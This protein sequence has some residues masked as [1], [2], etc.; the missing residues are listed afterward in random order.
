MPARIKPG[1]HPN[2]FGQIAMPKRYPA[3]RGSKRSNP[4]RLT[5]N[6]LS[7]NQTTDL[8]IAGSPYRRPKTAPDPA[9]FPGRDC[10]DD[11]IARVQA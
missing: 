8:T 4:A 3:E 2:G 6:I 10:P 11:A 9:D 7:P 5:H 1:Q